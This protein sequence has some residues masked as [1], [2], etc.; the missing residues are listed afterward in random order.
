MIVVTGEEVIAFQI[1]AAL[2]YQAATAVGGFPVNGGLGRS[3]V[4]TI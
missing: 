3:K 4:G 2:F 1:E